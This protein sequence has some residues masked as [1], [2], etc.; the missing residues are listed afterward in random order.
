MRELGSSAIM[1]AMGLAVLGVPLAVNGARTGRRDLVRG[2]YAVVYTN[3]ALLA[4][5]NLAMVWALVSHDFSVSYVSQVGSRATPLFY[6]I[7]SLWGALEG[8]ILFWA[9]VLALYS[10]L[11]SEEHTSE[12]QS[13]V[14]IVC[15]FLLEETII[16]SRCL[17]LIRC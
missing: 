12:L 6:T 16:S 14:N 5:A 9:W 4:V 1:V 17:T 10:T 15:R 8:S 2:A 3:W 7:I 13:H 11:R